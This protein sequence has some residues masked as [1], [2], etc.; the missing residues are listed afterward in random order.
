MISN[1]LLCILPC[2]VLLG[3]KIN[4]AD[5][6]WAYI[7]HRW[8]KSHKVLIQATFK[9]MEYMGEQCWVLE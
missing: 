3:S 6:G 4:Y 1:V 5:L 9:L 2:F 8:N 7:L